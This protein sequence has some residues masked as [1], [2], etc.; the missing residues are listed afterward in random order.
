MTEANSYSAIGTFGKVVAYRLLPGTDFLTGIRKLCD[1]RGI[2]HGALLSATG[3][4]Q[5]ATFM[6]AAPSEKAKLGAAYSEPCVK[7]G[8]IEV[9]SVQGMILDDD[10]KVDFHF[11]GSFTDK[12]LNVF[13]GHIVEGG[14]P[15]L[16]TL[17]G[18]VAELVGPKLGRRY[19]EQVGGRI[20][21]PVQG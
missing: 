10:G 4:L 16:V 12:D 1:E 7:A 17:E 19:D 6:V 15:V 18:V 11:H 2:R 3:S 14:N 8:P 5:K 20:L 9:L 13:G 21:H